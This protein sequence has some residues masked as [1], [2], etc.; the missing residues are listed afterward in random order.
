MEECVI[1]KEAIKLNI[2]ISLLQE[3]SGEIFLFYE[4]PDL[5]EKLVLYY[6]EPELYIPFRLESG[7]TIQIRKSSI[8]YFKFN[9]S[10]LFDPNVDLEVQ[11]LIT[12]KKDAE[13]S[14]L[15]R[16]SLKGAVIIES[17]ESYNR[18]LDCLNR[19]PDLVQFE[20]NEDTYLI[21]QEYIDWV[22]EQ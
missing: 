21:S 2:N 10:M 3:F 15:N 19:S 22:K 8:A 4:I 9:T 18:L 17:K 14:L 13:I 6:N 16:S 1:S 7:E 5:V 12:L 20:S 11:K